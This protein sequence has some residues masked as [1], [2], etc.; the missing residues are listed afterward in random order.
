VGGNPYAANAAPPEEASMG[1]PFSPEERAAAEGMAWGLTLPSSEVGS[2]EDLQRKQ[3]SALAL[4]HQA[5]ADVKASRAPGGLGFGRGIMPSFEDIDRNQDGVI[6]REEWAR[7]QR[8][9]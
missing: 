8:Y 1:A 9:S 3:E 2:L 5:M 6:S 4:V 7:A